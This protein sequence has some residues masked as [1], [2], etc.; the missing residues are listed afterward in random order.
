MK[1]CFL[2]PPAA[3]GWAAVVEEEKG[4]EEEVLSEIPT[5]A[6]DG[7]VDNCLDPIGTYEDD[8]VPERDEEEEG[9]MDEGCWKGIA[10]LEAV[11]AESL[12]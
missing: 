8:E 7:V 6:G 9:S 10:A 11:A 3:E 4:P 2:A 1:P 12:D 5:P